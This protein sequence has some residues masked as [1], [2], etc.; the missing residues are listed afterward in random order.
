MRTFAADI[1]DEM[2]IGRATNNV[3]QTDDF[4]MLGFIYPGGVVMV[5]ES[6]ATV[7]RVS[8]LLDWMPTWN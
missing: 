2:G 7:E 6:T 3:W 8:I 4:P 1:I 5:S